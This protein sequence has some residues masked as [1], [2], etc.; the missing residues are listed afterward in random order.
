MNI[1]SNKKRYIRLLIVLLLVAIT[2]GAIF[3]FR[4]LG[5]SQ[6][7]RRNREYEVSLVNAL[8]NSY[9]GIK[10]IKIMDPYNND[11]PGS[12]SCDISVQFNDSQTITYGINH[13]LTYKENHDGL[14]KGD[15]NE[16]IDQQWSI[17]Q[18]HIGKTESTILVRYSNG[19]TGE[20]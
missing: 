5:K 1:S 16:E 13:R 8:K 10:E 20:Q 19:E 2:A 11:K 18:K 6:E 7:E 12:W 9:Q 14:M 17:L 3:M 15:T 4:L